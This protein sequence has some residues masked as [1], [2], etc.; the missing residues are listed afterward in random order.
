MKKPYSEKLLTENILLREFSKNLNQS[1]LAWH[2]DNEDR[3]II[4]IE[5][6]GWKFQKDNCL[7]EKIFPGDLVEIKAGEYHRLIKGTSDLIVKII[8]D[9]AP[10][11]KK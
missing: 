6:N 10:K 5:G 4:V 3:K 8:K 11:E 1:N 7:P 9:N 2:R